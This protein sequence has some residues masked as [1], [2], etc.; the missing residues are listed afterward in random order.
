MNFV[1]TPMLFPSQL[2]NS[3]QTWDLFSVLMN[4]KPGKSHFRLN[5]AAALIFNYEV[6]TAFLHF[7]I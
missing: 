2:L 4:Q 5:R 3:S 7:S 6:A 1:E